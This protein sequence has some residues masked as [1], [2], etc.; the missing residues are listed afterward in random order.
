[1]HGWCL[2]PAHSWWSS[3]NTKE[4]QPSTLPAQVPKEGGHSGRQTSLQS[5]AVADS[6]NT[7]T[8]RQT[9][10]CLTDGGYIF[11]QAKMREKFTRMFCIES[12]GTSL[13]CTKRE[14]GGSVYGARQMSQT[15]GMCRGDRSGLWRGCQEGISC[16]ISNYYSYEDVCEWRVPC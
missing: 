1:M 11:L 10:T 8:P 12:I 3:S 14:D 16:S 15:E 9:H 2:F 7:G 5:Q 13:L 4:Y 6:E